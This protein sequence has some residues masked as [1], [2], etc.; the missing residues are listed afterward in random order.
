VG[1]GVAGASGADVVGD[2][3]GA[4]GVV[5]PGRGDV[6]D[7]GTGAGSGS[8]PWRLRRASF[9]RPAMESSAGFGSV[10]GS[11]RFGS[12]GVAAGACGCV[13][14]GARLGCS[15]AETKPDADPLEGTDATAAGCSVDGVDAG[16]GAAAIGA[17]AIAVLT[18][19][20]AVRA[21][22]SAVAV[23]PTRS[24]MRRPGAVAFVRAA[25]VFLV[26]TTRA[27]VEAGATSP[28]D[29]L[30]NA[31]AAARR[32]GASSVATGGEL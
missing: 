32:T 14:T 13:A 2:V 24:A 12:A 15:G 22:E 28:P 23:D 7:D 6:D 11:V 16:A 3:A 26:F 25:G 29:V 30:T 1:A 20:T 8:S 19:G 9:A 10:F 21:W 27:T 31:G 18:V 17:E 5:F 4:G